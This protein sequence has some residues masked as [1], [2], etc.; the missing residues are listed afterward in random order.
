MMKSVKIISSKDSYK[1]DYIADQKDRIPALTR[2]NA[3]FIEAVVRLDSNYAND[4]AITGPDRGYDPEEYAENSNGMYCGSTAYWFDRM[5]QNS[6]FKRNVLG[7]VIAIDRT[8]STH[9]EASV[10]G[11]IAMRNIICE[12]CNNYEDLINK[13]NEKF[14]SGNYN[15]LIALVSQPLRSKRKKE[16]RYNLSFATKFYS[17]ASTFLNESSRYSKYDNVVSA[18]LPMYAG[19]YLGMKIPKG[20]FKIKTNPKEDK[21]NHRLKVYEKY[22]DCIEKIIETL[23][24]DDIIISKDELDHIIWYGYK[25]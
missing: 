23:Q 24:S 4:L 19:I 5:K 18:A 13:L 2:K 12:Y 14:F 25:G 16:K 9:L 11:R 8:N 1:L 21:F 22:A 15:H 17:Y 3:D 6:D 7:A 10:N 20:A